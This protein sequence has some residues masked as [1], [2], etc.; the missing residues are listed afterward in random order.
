[1]ALVAA[2]CN[3]TVREDWQTVNRQTEIIAAQTR[4]AQMMVE[5]EQL[6]RLLRRT[7]AIEARAVIQSSINRLRFELEQLNVVIVN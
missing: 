4:R 3:V 5:L 1:L 2:G 6:E 7:V